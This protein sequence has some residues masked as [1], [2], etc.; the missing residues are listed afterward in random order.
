MSE[1][2]IAELKKALEEMTGKQVHLYEKEPD[3]SVDLD[4][5]RLEQLSKEA[6]DLT[7]RQ[8]SVKNLFLKFLKIFIKDQLK[9]TDGKKLDDLMLSKRKDIDTLYNHYVL[10]KKLA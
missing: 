7:L 4:Q 3:Y 9:M 1:Y 6:F 10:V 2:N 5:T 8:L